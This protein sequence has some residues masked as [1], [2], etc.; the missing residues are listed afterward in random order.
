MSKYILSLL[1]AF[2]GAGWILLGDVHAA[3]S[4][5]SCKM[6]LK[7]NVESAFAPRKFDEGSLFQTITGS[8]KQAAVSECIYTS[9]GASIKEMLSVSLLARR[10]PT[11][12]LGM[13]P[14]QARASAL[15]LKPRNGSWTGA[16]VHFSD[17]L[18]RRD[19]AAGL[20]LQGEATPPA[21]LKN[22]Q[23]HT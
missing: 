2:L 22:V 13:S 20:I 8:A 9:K 19:D 11:D 10:A 14:A 17:A 12:A 23:S 18:A 15:T 6:M 4:L 1:L 7:T 3:D 16:S 21:R 5:D